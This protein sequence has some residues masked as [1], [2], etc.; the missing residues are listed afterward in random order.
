MVE[1]GAKKLQEPPEERMR[2]KRKTLVDVGGKQY[3]LTR[4][5]MRLRLPLRQPSCTL[6]DQP[7]LRQL[8]QIF[9]LE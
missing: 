2:R 3:A 4:S 7:E 8:I 9:L 6:G 1:L 5:R